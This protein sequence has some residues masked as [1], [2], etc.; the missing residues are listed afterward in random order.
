[1]KVGAGEGVAASAGVVGLN[2]RGRAHQEQDLHF[3]LWISTIPVASPH[4]TPIS[5]REERHLR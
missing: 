1:M 3:G 4:R 2:Q 5:Q